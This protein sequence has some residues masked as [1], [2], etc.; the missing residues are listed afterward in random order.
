MHR[1]RIVDHDSPELM[2][3]IKVMH[4]ADALPQWMGIGDGSC[5]VGFG[6]ENGF[7]KTA[8]AG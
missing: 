2:H 5:D 1:L 8:S 7:R 3:P 6:Q 4:R